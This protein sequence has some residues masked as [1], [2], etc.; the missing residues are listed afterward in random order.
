MTSLDQLLPRP[1]ER[2]RCADHNRRLAVD[3]GGTAIRADRVV[4]IETPLPWPKPVFAHRLLAE[5]D[6]ILKAAV[7][8]TRTLA[9][10]PAA[11][12]GSEASDVVSVT[13]FDR[14]PDGGVVERWFE[15]ATAAEMMTLA[16]ALAADDQ[17]VLDERAVR[18]GPLEAPVVLICT[19]GTH[20]V[21]CGSDGTRFATEVEQEVARHHGSTGGALGHLRVH[22]V[23]HTGGHRFA[24]TAM[25]LPDGRMWADLDLD[26]L[27]RIVTRSGP[28]DDDLLGRCRGWWGA[29]TGPGQMAERAV[30]GQLGWMAENLNRFIEEGDSCDEAVRM[31]VTVGDQNSEVVY[32]IDVGVAREIPSIACR[33]P[34]GLPA[35]PSVEYEIRR[36][37][38]DGGR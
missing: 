10:V 34:G 15:P 24:P 19:Q 7:V 36:L 1:D 33:E 6:P 25:T 11:S 35:K 9:T 13:T 4:L 29:E 37:E 23:S 38:P 12:A 27:T 20:D 8:P 16:Q 17:A 32:G 26:L 5:V 30:F 31:T 28:V 18:S 14:G 2:V 3:P 21:C 22:R